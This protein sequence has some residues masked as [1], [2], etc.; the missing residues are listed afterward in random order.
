MSIRKRITALLQRKLRS[1]ASAPEQ[2]PVPEQTDIL[3]AEQSKPTR[4]QP[5]P[6]DKPEQG[7]HLELYGRVTCPYCVRVN[8][9]IAELGIE[10]EIVRR[11]T[12]YGSEWRE[13]L[14]DRTGRTQ[15]PCLFI[16]GEPLFESLDIID[17]LQANM[18]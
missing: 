13:H 16:N 1:R 14:R 10:D 8:R 2:Q 6:P 5:A 9:V 18:A 15:V 11:D 7:Y 4:E 12:A 17:W 3:A